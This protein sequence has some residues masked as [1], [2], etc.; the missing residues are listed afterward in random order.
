MTCWRRP[1]G[2]CLAA[3]ARGPVDRGHRNDVTQFLPLLEVIPPV[4]GCIGR[5]QRKPDSPFADCG[6]DH[7]FYG[8]PP[9]L[10]AE[11]AQ[12]PPEFA[13]STY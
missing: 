12:E 4:R 1:R 7:H 6:Y 5:R 9:A 3:A 11:L 10:P 13:Y 8:R 2:W